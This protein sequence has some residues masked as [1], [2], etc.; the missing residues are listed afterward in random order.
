MC[1]LCVC[2][3]FTS[4][5]PFFCTFLIGGIMPWIGEKGKNVFFFCDI[6]TFESN[7]Y[8]CVCT[9]VSEQLYSPASITPGIR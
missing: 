4:I 2:R 9:C 6:A 7:M 1:I 8:V 3:S 5:F